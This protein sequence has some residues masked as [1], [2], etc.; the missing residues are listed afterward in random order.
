M[1]ATAHLAIAFAL[2]LAFGDPRWLPHPVKLTGKLAASLE[3]PMRR[4]ISSAR[5]AGVV[6]VG[7]VVASAAL[8]A[9]ALTAAARHLHPL[10]GDAVSI[11]LLYTSFAA[12]DLAGH[13][14]TVARA[15]RAGNLDLA[16]RS[17]ARMVGRDT[18][19]L[20]EAGV[21][22]AA[23]ESVAEN[24]VDGVT[25]PLFYAALGGPVLA[26]AYKAVSTLD[27][28]FGYKN[29]RYIE[30]GWA[31][32]RLDDM[33]AWIPARLTFPL[34]VLAAALTGG[35][36]AGAWKYGAR[37][38]RKHSSPNAGW[39]EA[40]FAGALGVQF[41][42]PLE[43]GGKRIEMPRMGEPLEALSRRHIGRAVTLM[44]ATSLLALALFVA[45]RWFVFRWE[46][47]G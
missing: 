43:R 30:F 6:A 21:A 36:V 47:L 33:A 13:A 19:T 8:G 15:L 34:V 29:E 27:S 41:G 28:T 4:V 40:A 11:L 32:A 46:V 16:R 3:E 5:L 20:D 18:E 38:W 35:R 24:T 26:M 31:S 1:T 39:A 7:V 17:V 12:R 44:F 25:A 22:R 42:G 9:Y 10:A 45:A 23:A 2:D 14:A 37:D